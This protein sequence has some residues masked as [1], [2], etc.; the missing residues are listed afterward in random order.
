MTQ[1]ENIFSEVQYHQSLLGSKFIS[2]FIKLGMYLCL[3][4]APE[5]NKC[6]VVAGLQAV[7]DWAIHI[8]C[9]LW[10]TVSVQGVHQTY[11]E[12]LL[13]EFS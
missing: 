10:F 4:A 11:Q 6:L 12:R 1:V 8:H 7:L 2:T 13:L 5:G 3:S 9:Q